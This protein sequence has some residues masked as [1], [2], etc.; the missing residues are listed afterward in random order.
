[1]GVTSKPV[2]MSSTRGF[3]VETESHVPVK[4]NG[5]SVSVNVPSI[6]MAG[7]RYSTG[8]L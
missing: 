1:M 6:R 7:S 4:K 8:D 5:V 3:F 2:W